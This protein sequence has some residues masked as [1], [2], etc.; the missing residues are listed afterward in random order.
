VIYNGWNLQ[1]S[2][3]ISNDISHVMKF[4]LVQ[5]N[6][7]ENTLAVVGFINL[8]STVSVELYERETMWQ[9]EI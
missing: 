2:R 6:G 1:L 7:F 8:L 5:G 3:N 4:N 9:N